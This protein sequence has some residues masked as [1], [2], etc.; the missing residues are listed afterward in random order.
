MSSVL[1]KGTGREKARLV[2]A[3]EEIGLAKG[4][5]ITL[6]KNA[7]GDFVLSGSEES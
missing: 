5:R 7:D 1:R 2:D 3:L 4:D 6:K